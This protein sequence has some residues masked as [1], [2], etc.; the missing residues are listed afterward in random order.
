[1]RSQSHGRVSRLERT[2]VGFPRCSDCRITANF[3][4][5]P[6]GNL[7]KQL[8]DMPFALPVPPNLDVQNEGT[9]SS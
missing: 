3:P 5:L 4:K 8:S 7:E 1:M 6:K 2:G 9:Y